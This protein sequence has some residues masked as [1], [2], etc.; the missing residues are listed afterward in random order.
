[1][2]RLARLS[3]L[4][5]MILHEVAR[6][7]GLTA[8]EQTVLSTLRWMGPPFRQ[9]PT[10]LAQALVQ[11]SGG[12]TATLHRL[13]AAKLINR[14][15]HPSD[16]RRLLVELSER[17]KAVEKAVFDQLSAKLDKVVATI[18]SAD[19]AAA[20]RGVEVLL[21]AIEHAIQDRTT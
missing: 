14:V 3:K 9:T 19:L 16:K 2:I 12:V 21:E 11:T 20:E 10:E 4:N 15:P 1:M 5:E 17:G 6:E 8:A 18:D 13:E 7:H